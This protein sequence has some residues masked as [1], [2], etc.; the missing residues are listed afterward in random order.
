MTDVTKT[1]DFFGVT[2][3]LN[4]DV[5][6]FALMEFAE[7]AS[8]GQDGDTLEGLATL[9]RFVKECVAEGDRAKFRAAAR[10]HQAKAADLMK[11]V[12]AAFGTAAERPTGRPDDSSPG[13]VSTELKSVPNVDASTSLP[14]GR[15]DL[16]RVL[17]QAREA[18]ASA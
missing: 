13:P 6:E 17:Q 1:V 15:P 10:K 4:P 5:S 9:S 2:L 3:G 12:E 7:A 18:K 14:A 16:Q 11:I 8:D